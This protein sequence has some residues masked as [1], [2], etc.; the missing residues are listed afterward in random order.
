M[1]RTGIGDLAMKN[2]AAVL[3]LALV[4]ATFALLPTPAPA[5]T[6][7]SASIAFV[8]LGAD[9]AAVARLITRE[10]SCPPILLDGATQPMAMRAAPSVPDFPVLVCEAPIPLGTRQAAIGGQELPLPPR[11]TPQRVVAIGD[12]G[13]RLKIGHPFQACNDPA[14]WPFA[15]LSQAAADWRPDVIINTG[16]YLYR[17][18][19]CPAG[20]AG[21]AGSPFGD[22]WAAWYADFFQPALP[23]L[24]AAPW[25]MA[26]GDHEACGRGAGGYF[27]FLDPRP[28]PQTCAKSTE[29]YAVTLGGLRL[30][31][32]DTSDATNTSPS[33]IEEYTRQFG[34]ID[35][36][37]TGETWLVMHMPL[38]ALRPS[39][40][41]ASQR[42]DAITPSLQK[43]S[44]NRVPAGVT[45]V[46]SGHIHL[47]QALGFADRR[48]PQLVV[49]TGG[50][51]LDPDI[52][53]A[54][55]GQAVGGTTVLGGRAAARF[56]FTSLEPTGAPRTWAAALRDDRGVVQLACT[57]TADESRCVK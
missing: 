22:N 17:E 16:D 51:L 41:G 10:S 12:T 36:L 40:Q 49:G 20:N 21:C 46:I 3:G 47:F 11:G 52:R 14:A 28:M 43:A 1:L 56:G 24:R 54:L 45:Q 33:R 8:V 23:L 5:Q 7:Q 6:P 35:T 34:I 19:A 18:L 53:A 26:R 4:A 30:A 31:V 29:P 38:F 50:T 44:G 15:R 32:M 57:L 39:N 13:C 25:V 37:A 48:A 2:T 27:R 42:I 55:S 9:Q